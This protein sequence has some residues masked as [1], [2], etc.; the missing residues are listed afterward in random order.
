[1]LIKLQIQWSGQGVRV[2]P[3]ATPGQIAAF[4]QRHDVRM[5]HELQTVYSRFDGFET[6]SP[7]DDELFML[8]PLARVQRLSDFA[9]W[10]D[11]PDAF[12]QHF[13]FADWSIDAW[14][15]SVE[16][17]SQ[18]A[19]TSPVFIDY[20][21]NTIDRATESI[22]EFFARYSEGDVGVLHANPPEH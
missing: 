22:A 11:C 14:W 15:Y 9:E 1:M 19:L 2:R 3:G 5:P 20:Q 12:R 10:K 16:M 17:M 13:V 18:A 8:W 6:D 21:W 7:M 4:E